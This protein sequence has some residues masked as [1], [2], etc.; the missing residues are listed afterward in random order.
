MATIT[1]R[2]AQK[3]LDAYTKEQTAAAEAAITAYNREVDADTAETEV[4]VNADKAKAENEAAV[5]IDRAAVQAL[6]DR[7]AVAET[8]GNLGLMRSGTA[9]TAREGITRRRATT[10][11]QAQTTKQQTLSALS[12]R[13]VTARRQ[14][15]AKKQKNAATVRKTVASKVAEKTLT[16]G[17]QGG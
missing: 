7:Y 15:E 1:K 10:E 5:A 11:R 13:L 4:A 2:Q 12:Q 8:L 14:A 16:L 3:L 17:K 6:I 9:D